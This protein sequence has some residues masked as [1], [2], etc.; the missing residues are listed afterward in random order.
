MPPHDSLTYAE[1]GH[2]FFALAVTRERILAGVAGLAGNRIEF[3][4]KGVGPGRLAQVTAIGEV[5]VATVEPSAG[6]LIAFSLGVP[7][8]LDLVVDLGVDQH[9]FA[10]DVTVGLTITARAAD[11]LRVVIDVEPPTKDD[12]TVAVKAAGV[13]ASILQ[14]VAGVD[15]E[16]R[17]FVAKYVA[18]ELDKPHI[19]KARDI[20]VAERIDSGWR[21]AAGV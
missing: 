3:G 17:R 2:R 10:V 4:P 21:R 19:K 11:P 20:D 8:D 16:I 14:R 9:R 7:V 18:R 12:V 6:E 1:F 5:G 13:R 15:D